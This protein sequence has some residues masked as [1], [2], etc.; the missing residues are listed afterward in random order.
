M[1]IFSH[2]NFGEGYPSASVQLFQDLQDAFRDLG[3]NLSDREGQR[4]VDVLRLVIIAEQYH[5]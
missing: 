2:A 1:R 4:Q 5:F 3:S